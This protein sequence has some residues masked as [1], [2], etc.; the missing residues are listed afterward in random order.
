MTKYFWW[1]LNIHKTLI[2]YI[3]YLYLINAK[4]IEIPILICLMFFFNE[5]AINNN[6]HNV[7]KKKLKVKLFFIPDKTSE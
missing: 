7:R 2:K 1:D 5:N 6:L 3:V 4:N